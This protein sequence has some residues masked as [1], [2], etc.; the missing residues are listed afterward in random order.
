MSHYSENYI[1]YLQI[2]QNPNNA[3]NKP[4]TN[5]ILIK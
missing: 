1:F 5:D 4:A 3:T 2:L